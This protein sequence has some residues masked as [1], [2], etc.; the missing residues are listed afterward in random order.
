MEWGGIKVSLNYQ[1]RIFIARC[2]YSCNGKQALV[3]PDILIQQGIRG[4]K[5]YQR[6]RKENLSNKLSMTTGDIR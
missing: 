5:Q 4:D 2:G 3:M 1:N 6:K